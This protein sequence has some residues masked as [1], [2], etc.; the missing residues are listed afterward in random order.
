MSPPRFDNNLMNPGILADRPPTLSSREKKHVKSIPKYNQVKLWRRSF[1][2]PPPNGESLEM[3]AARAVA[4][5]KKEVQVRSRLARGRKRMEQKGKGRS[6]YRD[7]RLSPGPSKSLFP[8]SFFADSVKLLTT[9]SLLSPAP[10]IP[11][12]VLHAS[13][14][15]L[16]L[17]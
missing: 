4:Y 10:S 7:A 13:F 11:H 3:T 8:A 9:S 2:V 6:I 15:S 12:I 17:L 14:F 1:D 5:F 16:P